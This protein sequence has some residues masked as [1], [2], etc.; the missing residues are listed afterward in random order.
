VIY[1]DHN[2]TTPLDPRVR[3]AMEPFLADR[4]GNPSSVH[5]EGR[6]ARRAVE[7]ARESVAAWV[8]AREADEIV[9]TSGGTESDALAI[10]GVFAAEGR[11]PRSGLVISGVEHPAVREPARRL[12]SRGHP[13]EEI[14]VLASGELDLDAAGRALAARPSLVSVMAANNEYGA[15]FPIGRLATMAHAVGSLLH[16][17]AVAAAG[18]IAVDV[19]EW[20]VDLLSLSAHKIYGPKGTGALYVRKGVELEPLL[21]GGGQ[22]RRRRGGT[23]NVAGIVGFG[24]AARLSASEMRAERERERRLRDDLEERLR[25]AIPGLRIWGEGVPRIPNTSAVSLPGKSGEALLIRLDLAGIAIS[26]G[27]A[28]SSGTVSP[29]PVILALGATLEEARGTLRFSFGRGNRAEDLPK[30]IQALAG[31]AQVQA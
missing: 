25:E 1:L 30:V 13:V 21:P 18:K 7:E 11:T 19:R 17:D 3:D 9:F 15:V 2:A 8:G 20:D 10:D 16:T 26:V 4:F 29:S 22:E 6:A 12:R 24:A 14:P 28:C 5:S 27:S 23:E 31:A